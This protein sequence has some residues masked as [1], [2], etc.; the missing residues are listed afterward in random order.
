MS[1]MSFV[2][3]CDEN[4]V[5]HVGVM[6]SSLLRANPGE[7]IILFLLT[8]ASAAALTGVR[9]VADAH[10]G[11]V[12]PIAF[13]AAALLRLPQVKHLSNATYFRL[14]IAQALPASL[15][16]VI[17]LDSDV[18]VKKP[19]RELWERDLGGAIVGAV[20]E[21]AEIRRYV[22]P[23]IRLPEGSLYFNAGVLLIDLQRWRADAIGEAAVDVLTHQFER[24]TWADQCALN[25]V[26]HDKWKPIEPKWNLLVSMIGMARDGEITPYPDAPAILDKAA[27]VH[28]HSHVKPWHYG[29]QH[30]GRGLY[31][32]ELRRTPW[33]SYRRPGMI[34]YCAKRILGGERSAAV[35]IVGRI[36][37]RLTGRAAAPW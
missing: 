12:R 15:D 26:L 3:A 22:G 28:F 18:I 25:I 4:Y 6:L 9:E 13:D 19:V 10:G 8:T 34:K 1:P 31:W 17:Y 33:K 2:A 29:N 24:T 36:K 14:A 35:R 30:P 7:R 23:R 27:I 5:Q 32:D 20:A 37:D 11:E 16:R 21:G